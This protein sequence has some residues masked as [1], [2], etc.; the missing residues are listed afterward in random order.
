MTCPALTAG[1]C[2]FATCREYFGSERA[3]DRHRVGDYAKQDEWRGNR[4]R[5]TIPEMIGV[6]WC[7]NARG[8][9]LTPDP[10]PAGVGAQDPRVTLLATGITP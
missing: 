9:L 2:Q 10:R 4:R 8:F 5:L 3:F 1:R 7:R 6:G